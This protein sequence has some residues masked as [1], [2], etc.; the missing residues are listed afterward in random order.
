M[1]DR[2][3]RDRILLNSVLFSGFTSISW[4]RK[5]S[6]TSRNARAWRS[7]RSRILCNYFWRIENL[8]VCNVSLCSVDMFSW[9]YYELERQ[10]TPEISSLGKHVC[11][12]ELSREKKV[13]PFSPGDKVFWKRVSFWRQEAHRWLLCINLFYFVFILF[14]HIIVFV[15]IS[16]SIRIYF[17]ILSAMGWIVPLLSFYKDGLGIK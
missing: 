8:S 17:L 4:Y 10:R 13:R 15:Y 2:K 3:E 16:Y 11:S 6:W 14:S 5:F 9:R 1:N 7:R 12:D